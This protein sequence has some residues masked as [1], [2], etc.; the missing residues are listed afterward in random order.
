MPHQWETIAETVTTPWATPRKIARTGVVIRNCHRPVRRLSGQSQRG[1]GGLGATH[2]IGRTAPVRAPSVASDVLAHL[3]HQNGILLSPVPGPLFAAAALLNL[4]MLAR[5][6]RRLRRLRRRGHPAVT[7]DG[8]RTRTS[9]VVGGS[10]GGSMVRPLREP[11]L[12]RPA[13]GAP[14][15]AQLWDPSGEPDGP[16]VYCSDQARL[17]AIPLS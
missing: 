15:P 10:M 7:A 6:L 4:V 5:R 16:Q 1:E 8:T 2:G 11:G 14:R 13:S 3:S 12:V 9:G 17:A